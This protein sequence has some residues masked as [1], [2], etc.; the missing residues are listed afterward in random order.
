MAI[1]KIRVVGDT[2]DEVGVLDKELP[3]KGEVTFGP[4]VLGRL[5]FEGLAVPDEEEVVGGLLHV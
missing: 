3:I 1:N 5:V 2:L 4:I